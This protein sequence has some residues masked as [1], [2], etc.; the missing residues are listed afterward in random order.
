MNEDEPTNGEGALLL[1]TKLASQPVFMVCIIATALLVMYFVCMGVVWGLI[2]ND[3]RRIEM[4]DE[5]A[6]DGDEDAVLVAL[7]ED[8]EENG[9]FGRNTVSRKSHGMIALGI[10]AAVMVALAGFCVFV[11]V[12]RGSWTPTRVYVPVAMIVMMYVLVMMRLWVDS[13]KSVVV[14]TGFYL[15]IA[16][17]LAFI[18]SLL[19]LLP[20][21]R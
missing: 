18:W 19:F 16:S 14:R 21:S 5:E 10:H 1:L 9:G 15:F 3:I 17:V 6:R 8:I 20:Q 7:Y 4:K 11:H 13:R 2:K 12:Y